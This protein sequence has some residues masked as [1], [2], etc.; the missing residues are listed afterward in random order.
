MPLDILVPWIFFRTVFVPGI[1][2]LILSETRI[3]D[4][5]EASEPLGKDEGNGIFWAAL[6]TA[7]ELVE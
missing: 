5:G 6:D 4:V 2:F 3:I 1:L 7:I